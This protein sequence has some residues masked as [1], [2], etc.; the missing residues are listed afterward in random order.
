MVY[1]LTLLAAPA[2]LRR[3]VSTSCYGN[4]NADA[5]F[6]KEPQHRA[7]DK[8]SLLISLTICATFINFG[9]FMIYVNHTYYR[10]AW[11]YSKKTNKKHC[12]GSRILIY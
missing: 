11:L 3:L 12:N 6:L 4:K 10:V 1:G 8:C 2:R 9:I 7:G 5:L